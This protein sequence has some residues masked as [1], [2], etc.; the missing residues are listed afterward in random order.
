[1]Q[2][3]PIPPQRNTAPVVIPQD[4]PVYQAMSPCFFEDELLPVGTIFA[5]DDE[6]NQDMHP[7]NPLAADKL[8]AY[9]Q[10]LDDL[11][12]AAAEKAGRSYVSLADA[13]ENS[14]ALA[15]QDAKKVQIL[16]GKETVPLLGSKKRGRPPIQRVEVNAEAPMM[17]SKNPKLSLDGKKDAG[18]DAANKSNGGL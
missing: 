14:I 6:P 7:M 18:K 17:G 15:K 12:R 8:R 5:W 13:H 3:S 10:K 11:G 9:L 16:N 2:L 4:R 1:M